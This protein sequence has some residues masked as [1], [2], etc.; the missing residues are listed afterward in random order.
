MAHF[1]DK[2]GLCQARG[3]TIIKNHSVGLDLVIPQLARKPFCKTKFR[4]AILARIKLRKP[5]QNRRNRRFE[6][7]QSRG[8]EWG[9]DTGEPILCKRRKRNKPAKKKNDT[10]AHGRELSEPAPLGEGGR[11]LGG[12]RIVT[13]DP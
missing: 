13:R 11:E 4:Q 7:G 12:F 1:V 10:T 5:L 8:V 3:K 9:S 2:H 6:I